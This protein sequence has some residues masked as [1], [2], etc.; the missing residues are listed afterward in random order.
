MIRGR[1]KKYPDFLPEEFVIFLSLIDHASVTYI[2][3]PN[4]S[5]VSEYFP[6]S[7]KFNG[8][9]S[10]ESALI[11]ALEP[12]KQA[13][14]DYITQYD[15][16]TE[17]LFSINELL[18]PVSTA[19]GFLSYENGKYVHLYVSY[20]GEA[21]YQDL[22]H[23][24][25]KT[26]L[27]RHLRLI[28]EYSDRMYHFLESLRFVYLQM[29][30]EEMG[31]SHLQ[32]VFK[33]FSTEKK[34]LYFLYYLMS[35]DWRQD[36]RSSLHK[37]KISIES[38]KIDFSH[39]AEV[40]SFIEID[41]KTGD[42]IL[43][44]IKFSDY[45]SE[46][47]RFQIKHSYDAI[48]AYLSNSEDKFQS[49]DRIKKLLLKIEQFI[50][51]FR[52]KENRISYESSIS[53]VIDFALSLI[54]KYS[55][56]LAQEENPELR[57]NVLKINEV[58]NE[59]DLQSMGKKDFPKLP[60]RIYFEWSNKNQT[61]RLTSILANGLIDNEF[62]QKED[63][64]ILAQV[65][66]GKIESIPRKIKWKNKKTELR[67]AVGLNNLYYLFCQ[68]VENSLLDAKF[69]DEVLEEVLC[70]AFIK[71]NGEDIIRLASAKQNTLKSISKKKTVE[72]MKIDVIV[73]SMSV[74][75]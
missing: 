59:S 52:K 24:A 23:L 25:K 62:I 32:Q 30:E 16:R 48:D 61:E 57:F 31:R 56:Y 63:W 53:H 54:E 15:S 27:Q 68:L 18:V 13:V 20:E 21:G 14:K 72:K 26:D 1:I 40:L 51:A 33:I 71:Y 41:Q 43:H 74:S 4:P 34:P 39:D 9:R 29:P 42:D 65:F 19:K 45:L 50:I 22:S 70:S 47:I 10:F 46:F 75:N 5:N 12:A 35:D 38:R 11:D 44:K 37:N 60:P 36:L 69:I 6:D 17:A 55:N 8:S 2:R 64:G 66:S 67:G 28:K 58:I 49:E 73:K 7:F 3:N